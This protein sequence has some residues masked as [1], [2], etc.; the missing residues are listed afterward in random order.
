L[1]AACPPQAKRRRIVLQGEAEHASL[2]D[3]ENSLLEKSV[4]TA[5]STRVENSEESVPASDVQILRICP[6]CREKGRAEVG[7]II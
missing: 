2:G 3:G 6:W 7:P 4:K 5:F 1:A